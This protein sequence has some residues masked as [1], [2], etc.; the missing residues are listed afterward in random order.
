M[1]TPTLVLNYPDVLILPQASVSGGVPSGSP[2]NFGMIMLIYQL[3]DK[4][5]G[6]DTVSYDPTGQT[7][8]TYD[9]IEYA[10]VKESKILSKEIAAL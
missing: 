4:Y 3:S 1:A 6:G 8:A 7:L 9:G 5:Q 2:I 10:L